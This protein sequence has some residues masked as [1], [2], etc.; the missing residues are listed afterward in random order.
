MLIFGETLSPLFAEHWLFYR[1]IVPAFVVC[2]VVGV[3]AHLIFERRYHH[4]RW[5]G[6]ALQLSS[7]IIL[8]LLF[9]PILVIFCVVAYDLLSTLFAIPLFKKYNIFFFLILIAALLQFVL[10][11]DALRHMSW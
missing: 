2:V 7:A 1:V 10:R 8:I 5:L 11:T 4:L 9:L 3:I 6:H